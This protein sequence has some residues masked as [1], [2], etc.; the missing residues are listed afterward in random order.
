MNYLSNRLAPWIDPRV[1]SVRVADLESY[2]LRN[3]WKPRPS[4]RPQMLWFEEPTDDGGKPIIQ[5]VPSAE[6]GSDYPQRVIEVITNLALLEDR[7]A[8]EV[9]N[10]VL[11]PSPPADNGPDGSGKAVRRRKAPHGSSK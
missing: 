9:L 4:P 11:Q 2:L 10:D 5:A 6:R 7:Y 3:G 1:L 8:V